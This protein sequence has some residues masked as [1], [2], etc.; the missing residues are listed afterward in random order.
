MSITLS[1]PTSFTTDEELMELYVYMMTQPPVRDRGTV[2]KFKAKAL[3][4]SVPISMSE[5][6][7]GKF[8]SA[9]GSDMSRYILRARIESDL[10]DNQDPHAY[11][12]NPCLPQFVNDATAALQL[13][14]QHTLCIT[15]KN[16]NIQKM[17]EIVK[18][19][20]IQIVCKIDRNG[21][22]VVSN[23]V[24]TDLLIRAPQKLEER[25]KECVELVGKFNIATVS[26][27]DLGSAVDVEF[28]YA[29]ARMATASPKA[30]AFYKLLR[31][32][33]LPSEYSDSF[34]I[35]LAAN[36]Q[37]ESNFVATA[38][39]DPRETV[40]GNSDQAIEVKG[41]Y[42]CSFGYW[43]LNV[44]SG[45]GELFAKK[46]GITDIVNNK[47]KLYKSI[48]NG[49]KQ[50]EYM[51]EYMKDLF[52]ADVKDSSL[53]AEYWGQRIAVEFERCSHC[54]APDSGKDATSTIARGAIAKDLY[55]K[56]EP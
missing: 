52:G 38:N 32:S 16:F 10:Y 51:V 6:T 35:G 50:I 47:A 29:S 3:T 37:A 53:S 45:G 46:Q 4:D 31:Q 18:G 49:D 44:C 17:P 34:V 36:A 39:G 25:I 8:G 42:Y 55:G 9:T 30:A 54:Y 14:Q 12:D 15:D 41:K 13:I 11:L 5:L 28:D 23:A 21:N 56:I 1:D 48:T 27:G 33:F 2:R 19:D 7:A 24:V 43:Q 40:G 20:I 26:L 22:P